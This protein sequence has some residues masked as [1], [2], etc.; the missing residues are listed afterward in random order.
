MCTTCSNPYVLVNN[1]CSLCTVLN[2]QTCSSTSIATSCKGGY[3][4]SS[5]SCNSCLLNCA[6]CSSASD[7]SSCTTG[8]YLNSSILTCNP[9]P[10][11]CASCNQFTP[12]TCTSCSN[13]YQLVGSSCTQVTCSIANC[14]HCSSALVC[15][16]CNQYYYWSGSACVQGGSVSC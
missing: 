4:L 1:L 8:Y 7:C 12:T 9:C 2:A 11:G 16:Q 15:K 5:G 10:S 6:S 14:M 13:G 3:Y